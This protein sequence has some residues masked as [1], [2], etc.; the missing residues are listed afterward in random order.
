MLVQGIR[1]AQRIFAGM[2]YSH[3]PPTLVRVALFG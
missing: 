3:T 1:Q 2:A